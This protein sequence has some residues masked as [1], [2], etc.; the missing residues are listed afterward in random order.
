MFFFSYFLS[1]NVSAVRCLAV[2]LSV[3]MLPTI[4]IVTFE[5]INVYVCMC[6]TVAGRPVSW[7]TKTD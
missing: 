1:V 5:Q 3:N 4:I 2:L 6:V 7:T